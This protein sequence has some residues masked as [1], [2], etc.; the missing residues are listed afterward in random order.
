ME[1]PVNVMDPSVVLPAI[2]LPLT[3][4]VVIVAASPTDQ[5]TLHGCPPPA[6]TTEKFVPVRA[7]PTMKIQTPLEGPLS[8][9]VVA[10]NVAPAGKQ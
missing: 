4:E 6:I 1:P 7:A 5:N 8:V 10:V 9:N 2:M 3:D